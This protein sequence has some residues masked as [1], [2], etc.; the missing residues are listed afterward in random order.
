[1]VN[2]SVYSY[3]VHSIHIPLRYGPEGNEIG[4]KRVRITGGN[5]SRFY[6]S[7]VPLK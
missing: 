6:A 7:P 1:L 4:L 3:R 2:P 5:L